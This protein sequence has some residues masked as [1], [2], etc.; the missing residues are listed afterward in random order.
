[1]STKSWMIIILAVFSASLLLSVLLFFGAPAGNTAVVSVD[2]EERFRL[3]LGE[4]CEITV[5]TGRGFNTITVSNGKLAVSH[6]DC[7]TQICVRRG[8]ANSGM[9]IICLPHRLSIR[10]LDSGTI[11]AWTR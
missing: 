9:P 3:D 10:F 5:D 11:D 7:P 4:D 1:M 2:G 6:S 8:Y